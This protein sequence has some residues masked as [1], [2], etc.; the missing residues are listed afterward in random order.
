MK[1]SKIEFYEALKQLFNNN[2]IVAKLVYDYVE[3]PFGYSVSTVDLYVTVEE[4]HGK[5][6]AKIFAGYLEQVKNPKLRNNN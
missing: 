2:E 4:I 5:E 3:Q 1:V 6:F